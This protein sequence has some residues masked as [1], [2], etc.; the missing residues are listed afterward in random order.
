[1]LIAGI[2][3]GFTANRRIWLVQALPAAVALIAII[4]S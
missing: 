4:F 2:Y 1:V 3:G